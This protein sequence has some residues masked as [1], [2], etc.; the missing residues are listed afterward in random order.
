MN[1]KSGGFNMALS[2]YDRS[3]G[4]QAFAREAR[5]ANRRSLLELLIFNSIG[6]FSRVTLQRSSSRA[7]PVQLD[8]AGLK[9]T[10]QR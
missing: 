5:A 4:N 3:T 1:A 6:T 9:I 7:E 8:F 2:T 10:S